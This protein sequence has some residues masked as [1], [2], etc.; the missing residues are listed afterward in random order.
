MFPDRSSGHAFAWSERRACQWVS[1][2]RHRFYGMY[3]GVRLLL[4]FP[5]KLLFL[6]SF[7]LPHLHF[8]LLYPPS[9]F[10]VLLF[11]RGRSWQRRTKVMPFLFLLKVINYSFTSCVVCY[12][13]RKDSMF[14]PCKHLSCCHICAKKIKAS[15]G[16]CPICRTKITSVIGQIFVWMLFFIAEK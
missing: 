10:L 4:L 11:D 15:K 5:S 6:P 9:F 7:P 8:S 2:C 16:I 13:L 12:S 1:R 14:M 3:R